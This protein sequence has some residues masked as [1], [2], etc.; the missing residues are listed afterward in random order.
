M[1]NN[2]RSGELFSL[3]AEFGIPLNPGEQ[4]SMED[5]TFH[6]LKNRYLEWSRLRDA[7]LSTHLKTNPNLFR[8]CVPHSRRV[9][10]LASQVVWYLDEV[11]IPDPVVRHFEWATDDLEEDKI[12]LRELI[13]FLWQF[14]HPIQEGYMLLAGSALP[15]SLDRSLPPIV[16]ELLN[17]PDVIREL[18]A[19]TYCG[20]RETLDG[21]GN[22][23]RIYQLR[24][25]SGGIVGVA[26]K[27][28]DGKTVVL[29]VPIHETLP[30]IEP[31]ELRKRLG[32]D[33]FDQIDHLFSREIQR[34]LAVAHYARES[35]AIPLFD[36]DVHATILNQAGV[37]LDKSQQIAT[38][39]TF[40]LTLP[41]VDGV[42]S[43]FLCELRTAMPQAFADFRAR[44]FQIVQAIHSEE[45]S[46]PSEIRLRVE[47]EVV[48]HLRELD[49]EIQSALSK[50]RVL[51]LGAPLA[52]GIGV[53]T[54]AIFAAPISTL[55]TLGM[56]GAGIG[57]KAISEATAAKKKA[58]RHPFYFLWKAQDSR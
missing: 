10:Q 47:R 21:A 6:Q 25:D 44:M 31:D 7:D 3:A 37:A 13:Q 17:N 38:L 51:G 34:A 27:I 33:P 49:A 45:G 20:Y 8:A 28:P 2:Y 53:L 40:D 57:L 5:D 32:R 30:P 4:A 46:H 18:R 1:A 50:A 29:P 23:T 12:Q 16:S 36:R 35:G 24:L 26:G 42:P 55:L 58:E 54:G 48:P 56:A 52:S 41:Y 22:P 15:P 39:G 11:I 43:E 19:A 14:R 9:F